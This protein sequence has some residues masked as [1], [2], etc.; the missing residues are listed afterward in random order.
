[1]DEPRANNQIINVYVFFFLKAD[2]FLLVIVK[3]RVDCF[4]FFVL[5]PQY[6]LSYLSRDNNA[7]F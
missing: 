5:L 2:K 7:N 3:I 6:I 1:M 4:H